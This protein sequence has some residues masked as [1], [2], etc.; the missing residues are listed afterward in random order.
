MNMG[1]LAQVG[2]LCPDNFYHF[3]FDIEVYGSTGNQPTL[4]KTIKLDKIARAAGYVKT[5]SV[6]NAEDL[7]VVAKECLKTKGPAFILIKVNTECNTGI[8]RISHC[9][10]EIKKRFMAVI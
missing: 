10:E 2:T 5:Y 1:T 3:V 7:H 6:I 9:P 8:E 4:T